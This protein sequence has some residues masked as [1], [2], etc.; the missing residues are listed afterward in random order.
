MLDIAHFSLFEVQLIYLTLGS[1][2]LQET[3]IMLREFVLCFD[4]EFVGMTWD[5]TL[6]FPLR[7]AL[8]PTVEGS[9]RH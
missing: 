6:A 1:S 2:C 3:V 4:V 7:W 5:E 9:G 8:H